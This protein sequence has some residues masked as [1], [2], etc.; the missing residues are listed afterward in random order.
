MCIRSRVSADFRL[1]QDK[2]EVSYEERNAAS[3]SE[4][5]AL[6]VSS[7]SLSFNSCHSIGRSRGSEV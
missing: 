1:V 6:L 2:S 4:G 7:L 3:T 5:C